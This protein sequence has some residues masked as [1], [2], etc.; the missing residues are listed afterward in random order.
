MV[1][2]KVVWAHLIIISM[3]LLVYVSWSFIREN[4]ESIQLQ[5]FYWRLLPVSLGVLVLGSLAIGFLVSFL[6]F[7]FWGTSLLW[8]A[9]RLRRET[10]SLQQ[11]LDRQL[12]SHSASRADGN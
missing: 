6:I 11:M 10:S 8:E 2:S 4:P 3:G 7:L 5:I 9:R 12:A 1:M